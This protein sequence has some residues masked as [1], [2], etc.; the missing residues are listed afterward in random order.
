MR[1]AERKRAV[2][3]CFA[4]GS[5]SARQKG[6]EIAPQKIKG[7]SYEKRKT[8]KN[9]GQSNVFSVYADPG[10]TL[11]IFLRNIRH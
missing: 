4:V 1:E 6:K 2:C 7:G 11:Y 9:V 5:E 10:R 8:Q 3:V